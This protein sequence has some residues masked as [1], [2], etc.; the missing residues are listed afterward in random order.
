MHK[1]LAV[2]LLFLAVPLAQAVEFSVVT[3][4]GTVAFAVPDEWRVLSVQTKPPISTFAFQVPNAADEGTPHSTNVAVTLFHTEFERG[5]EA[6]DVPVRKYGP[7]DP[8]TDEL[9]GWT[10][11][12]Q[13]ATQSDAQYV[14]VDAKKPVGDVVAAVRFAWPR[15]AANDS[16]YDE[17]MHAAL[18]RLLKSMTAATGVP[19]QGFPETMVREAKANPGGWVYEIWGSY[20]PHGEVPPHAI[21]GAWRVSDVGEIIPGSFVANPKFRPKQ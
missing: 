14:I 12:T 15:L 17:Q 11:H 9:D 16:D 8:K 13:E 2:L 19:Q 1:L 7:K 10:I 3:T 5:R 18:S 21:K 6:A 20:D 4:A